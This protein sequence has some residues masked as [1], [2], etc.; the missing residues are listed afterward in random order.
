MKFPCTFI[1][2][3]R[4]FSTYDKHIPAPFFRKSFVNGNKVDKAKIL[5]TGLGFYDLYFNGK[6]ITKGYIAP[7]VSNT[8]DLVYYDE[9]D[10]TEIMRTGENV[11]GVI[12]GNGMQNAF[13]GYVWD[14]DKAVFR[15]APKL[16]MSFTAIC[17][18]ETIE[19]ESDESFKTSS[20]PIIF[21]EFRSGEFYD[22]RLE[23]ENWCETGFDDLKW[24]NA[25]IVEKPRGEKRI[26][27]AEPVKE[28][29][30][31]IPISITECDDGFLYD[32][33]I[34][35][36]GVCELKIHGERGQEITLRHSDNIENGKFYDAHIGQF[37]PQGYA[38]TDKYICSGIGYETY[39]PRFTYHC[40][41]YV[42][43]AGI[44]KEQATEDLLTFIVIHSDIESRG[45][46]ICSDE[47]LNR[48]QEMTR[49]STIS[50][51]HYFLTD[52]PHREK[53]GWTADAAL[54]TEQTLLNYAPENSLG[55]WM[56]NVRKAMN[57]DGALPGIVP[58]TGWGFHWGNGP[59]WDCALI[60]V[61]FLI[62]IYRGNTEILKDNATAIFRYLNYLTTRLNE[63]GLLE[64]GLGDWCN[65]GRPNSSD[66]KAPLIVTDS[67]IAMDICEKSAFIY[68]V[69]GMEL[70]NEFAL[71]FY[72]RLRANIRKYL[73]DK[74]N[75]TVLGNCQTAQAFGLY[76]N[77]FDAG[78]KTQAFERLLELIEKADYHLDVGVL[79][80]KVLFHTLSLFG[81]TDIA[82]KIITNPTFPSYAYW[83]KK[84][85]TTLWEDFIPD[86]LPCNSKNHYFWGDISAWFYQ[87]LGG[88]II[89]PNRN[90]FKEI[91]ISPCFID[92][93]DYVDTYHI[94]NYGRISVMW[95][96]ESDCI[97]LVLEIPE[98]L[99]GNIILEYS[100][101]F[102]D[103]HCIKKA[104]TGSYVIKKR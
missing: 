75:M 52:C 51:F 44:N 36:S 10:V 38:Q 87:R 8:D 103:G 9:Y 35:H 34:V 82:Y 69:L 83:I 16:A 22:A 47:T 23:V 20:S 79:G 71:K 48:L 85:A 62:Y 86:T 60:Y 66:F 57:D 3:T 29:E 63:K 50:N 89:N 2:A 99:S 97:K 61:P 27:T 100:Y 72:N 98:D 54:S 96:K 68:D 45:S 101:E 76:Y 41:R 15:S 26:C 19:F 49:R 18:K 4:E 104:Q 74:S 28:F 7:Y 32:F 43:V 77:I 13:G 37:Y 17:G 93:I 84:G 88:I 78:E 21:D 56:E 1:S 73:I 59:A 31:I 81:R 64:I 33:G 46:F 95:K 5:I 67:I 55:V 6:R 40:F 53:N 58:T 70:Q 11:I 102:D 91:R 90:N 25:I 42:L 80:G 92:E 65:A 30:R 14:F 24:P 12:L 39:K 94:T